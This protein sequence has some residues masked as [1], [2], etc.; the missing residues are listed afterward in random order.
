MAIHP[1]LTSKTKGVQKK[2]GTSSAHAKFTQS[3]VARNWRTRERW[4]H[5]KNVMAMTRYDIREL[6]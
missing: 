3:R 6:W 1:G 5:P 2:K 4:S